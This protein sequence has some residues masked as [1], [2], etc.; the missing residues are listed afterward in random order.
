MICCEHDISGIPI[1][2]LE[3]N[4]YK[5][6]RVITCTYLC[7]TGKIMNRQMF[8]STSLFKIKK[9]KNC[10][11]SLCLTITILLPGTFWAIFA[12][13]AVQKSCKNSPK[14]AS[15]LW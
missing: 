9:K 1:Y 3:C 5:T 11:Y 13:G 4:S 15:N 2:T 12:G 8:F 6:I 7:C 10:E 14:C